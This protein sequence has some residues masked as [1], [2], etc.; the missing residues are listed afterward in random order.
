MANLAADLLLIADLMR[1]TK[2]MWR[3]SGPGYVPGSVAAKRVEEAARRLE[4]K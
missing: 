3:L 2:R 1:G 4:G